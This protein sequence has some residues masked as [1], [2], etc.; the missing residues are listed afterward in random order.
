M[1]T[2]APTKI[3][4]L[5]QQLLPNAAS[6]SQVTPIGLDVGNG[7]VKLTSSMGQTLMESYVYYLSE[8]ATH[9]NLGYVEY[10]SGDRPDLAGKQWIGGLNAYF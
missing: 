7:A 9:A 2:T 10:L 3:P 6:S 1:N 8:R 5:N 4:Q